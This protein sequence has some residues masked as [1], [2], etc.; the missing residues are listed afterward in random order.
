MALIVHRTSTSLHKVLLHI[1]FDD[2]LKCDYIIRFFSYKIN[3]ICMK[4]PK[5]D[6]KRIKIE[7]APAIKWNAPSKIIPEML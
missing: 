1:E 3:I 5:R 2:F 4:R 6:I 7:C